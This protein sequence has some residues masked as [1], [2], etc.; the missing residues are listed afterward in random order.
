MSDEQ[1]IETVIRTWQHALNSRDAS[2]LKD[3]W[4]QEYDGLTY[5]AEENNDALTDWP[6]ISAYYDALLTNRISW[7][8]D[9]LK[10]RVLGSGAWVYLTF[11]ASGNVEELNHEFLW[12]GR[13]S[14]FLRKNSDQWKIVHYHE[15]LSRD[16]SQ[17]AWGWFFK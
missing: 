2:A 6:S 8:V 11:I 9:S 5:V 12:K 16:R 7:S 4:A 13:S 3:G 17:E 15:S 14:F 1:A 10:V